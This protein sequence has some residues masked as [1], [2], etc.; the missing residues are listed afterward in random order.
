MS[1]RTDELDLVS[2]AWIVASNDENSIITY[3]GI[4]YRLGLP[5]DYDVKRLIRKRPELFRPGANPDQ[6][7]A[8]TKDMREGRR[9][10]SWIR[11]KPEAER[12]ASVAALSSDDVFR[13]QFRANRN[14]ERSPIEIISWG[15]E[16]LDRVR[17][18]KLAALDANAKSWQMWLLF[19][20]GVLGL[21]TQVLVAWF[22]G[23]GK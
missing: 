7:E 18:A 23:T 8:W 21:V 6:F 15:L 3:E 5:P 22:K 10:P 19:V 13:S 17:K 2:V 12:A 11:A 9:L 16:H 4:R 20:V 1:D 14:A